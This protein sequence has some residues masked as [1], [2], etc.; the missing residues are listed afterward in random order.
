AL[1]AS[2]VSFLCAVEKAI[3]LGA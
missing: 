2:V 1:A 3:A